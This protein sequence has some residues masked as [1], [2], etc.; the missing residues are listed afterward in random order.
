M[1]NRNRKKD[2]GAFT[3]V[4]LLVV[5]AIIGMLIALL[6]PA[7][8]AA[9]EAARR[10]QCTNHLKQIA[11]A[12]HNHADIKS[13]GLPPGSRGWNF[14][15][16]TPFILPFIEQQ[17][18]YNMMTI[19]YGNASSTAVPLQPQ[20]PDFNPA[21]SGA[22]TGSLEAGNYALGQNRPAYEGRISVL[23]CPS[24]RMENW[25]YAGTGGRAR[26]YPKIS[27]AACAGSTAVREWDNRP[28]IT[29]VI[30]PPLNVLNG[31]FP[32]YTAF[33]AAVT[34]QDLVEPAG[35]IFGIHLIEHAG[36]TWIN[37]YNQRQR[38]I[39]RALTHGGINL[40]FV[41]DGLSN[42]IM[43]S[44]ILQ[45][46]NAATGDDS[47]KRGGWG[48]AEGNMFTTYF[49]PN[50]TQADELGLGATHCFNDPDA[51][52]PCVATAQGRNHFASAQRLSARSLHTG[53]VN[54]ARG[55]GS[56]SFISNTVSR[57]VWRA[58]G[59]ARSGES[60]SL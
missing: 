46:G 50:T 38:N 55:D 26:P 6:L 13:G 23:S 1:S 43:F 12:C 30:K 5:I 25:F 56:V 41:E 14:Q 37:R 33:G 19:I 59:S 16:W 32:Q 11:L 8:Q 2:F 20:P 22:Y 45:A 39:N 21:L 52:T 44:E 15:T 29:D 28:V 31:W 18:R 3:L 58:L 27:Y 48:R 60:V 53:G 17:A 36:D 9:R 7:V 40:S 42:T 54:A 35:A 24:G 34:V 57:A 51:G 4:E 10:M 49:E 47:D